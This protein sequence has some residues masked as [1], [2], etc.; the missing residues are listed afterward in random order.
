MRPAGQCRRVRLTSNV[1]PQVQI[2]M[3]ATFAAAALLSTSL[4]GCALFE[5]LGGIPYATS[6]IAVRSEPSTTKVFECVASSVQQLNLLRGTWD[7]KVSRFDVE[8]GIIETGDYSESN[9]IGFRVR[10]VHV[11][12]PHKV[13]L[14][15]K[16][17]G[18]YYSDL[19]ASQ[20]MQQLR[21][22]VGACVEA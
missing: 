6:E 13:Q 15:L 14:F 4:C 20:G 2:K 22:S 17:A 16:A 10:A 18:P 3:R 9:R 8:L 12:G 5:A 19:G 7:T 1:R 21:A 11:R